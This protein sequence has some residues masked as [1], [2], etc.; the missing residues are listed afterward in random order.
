M[1]FL[2]NLS[3]GQKLLG[4][5]VIILVIQ[6]TQ[7][8]ITNNGLTTMDNNINRI[9][10][11]NLPA[12]TQALKL[13]GS[14]RD[15]SRALGFYIIT[16]SPIDKIIYDASL[17]TL[18][19]QV[20]ALKEQTAIQ[21][22]PDYLSQLDEIDSLIKETKSTQTNLL[23]MAAEPNS[24]MPAMQFSA[25]NINPVYRSN[26]QLLSSMLAAEDEEDAS[27]ERREL[28]NS[29]V[30]LRYYWNTINNELRLFLAFRTAVAVDNAKLYIE[31]A[32]KEYGKLLEFSDLFNFE[33]EEAIDKLGPTLDKYWS[34]IDKMFA[35]H[36]SEEWRQDAFLLRT[37]VSPSLNRIDDK[38]NALV[39]SL[40]TESDESAAE[41]LKISE[42]QKNITLVAT[43]VAFIVLIFMG[44]SL[45]R[46][47][48]RPIRQA[49]DIANHIASGNLNNQIKIDV[50]D[51]TGEMLSTLDKMQT[52][53]RNR[54]ESDAKVAAENLRIRQALD[55]VSVSVT[56][57]NDENNLIYLNHAAIELMKSMENQ[58]RNQ[59]P[60]FSVDNLIGDKIS[61]YLEDKSVASAYQQALKSEQ[62]YNM[63][64]AER[65]LHLTAS[66]V[67]DDSGTYQGRVTQWQDI[68]DQLAAEQ[69]ERNRIEAE[70]IVASENARIRVALD[71]VTTNVML[72][73]NDRNIIYMNKNATSLFTD[74]QD[75]I[76]SQLPNF[77]P[78][79]L[80]GTNIDGFH[81][82]PSHQV[83]LLNN[84]NSTFE[85]E[86]LIG[87][88]TMKIIATPVISDEGERLGT[89]VEWGDRTQE[90]AV[91]KEI[92]ELVEAAS[93]GNL[94]SR[95]DL[96]NKQGFFKQLGQGINSLLDQ[97]TGVFSDIAR[98]MSEM[99]EG[100][101]SNKIS[102]EYQGTFG[103]VK[104]DINKT[105]SNLSGVLGDL[106]EAAESI[107]DASAEISD[108]NNN[109]SSRTEQQ[110]SNLEE[111]A[112]SMEELTSTVQHNSTNAQQAN[113]VASTARQSAEKGGEVVSSAISAMNEISK[114]SN[115]I[116]EIIG[117]IDEIAFQTNLLALNA[118]VEAARAGEQ[119]RGF[120]VVATEVRNLASRSAEAAKEIKELIQDSQVKVKSGTDLVNQ[121][122]QTLDEIVGDVKKVGDIVAEIAASSVQQSSGIAQV[123]EAVTA[124]DDLTQQNAALAEET[125]AAS[126][127]MS[128][129]AEEMLELVGFFQLDSSVK[130]S[131]SPTTRTARPVQPAA[132][133]AAAKPVSRLAPKPSSPKPSS[134]ERPKATASTSSSSSSSIEKVD[135]KP[136]VQDEGDEWEEF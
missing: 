120:A 16:Q 60:G 121:S 89:A 76:R 49:V 31:A 127:S 113:Q 3:I 133:Q 92:D 70:R 47:I 59:H 105:I 118:S 116:A 41:A 83:S 48:S 30:A 55:N 14:L 101:L 96:A 94:V 53:L 9:A 22:N 15:S 119:G 130:A 26:L 95:I 108:G 124:I 82:N 42:D 50:M 79:S 80:I 46:S 18:A 11:T 43:G 132:T 19:S 131:N 128:D 73:D 126:A 29:I 71:N 21:N 7:M 65:N 77:D 99:S 111:T 125:S 129:K 5:F 32:Q 93:Q 4:S 56:V 57:S 34:D 88:L 44:L 78:D 106:K 103:E 135:A 2:K 45:S 39:K 115:Q 51:E 90:V 114:S 52:D 37:Q 74:N 63:V 110:A 58:I 122:G 86:L 67:Y 62:E 38:I 64:L 10:N 81:E 33:Q 97:L 40:Q 68:T 112:A 17:S 75:E 12:T 13:S 87:S 72:A 107:S 27:E 104:N 102:R 61:I 123:N 24:N 91:E 20:K 109:L 134:I 6:A 23:S 117:V 54:I 84:L 136:A 8:V 28:I 66:P 25:D 1:G 85:S 35:L 98:V 36:K 69:E 100:R